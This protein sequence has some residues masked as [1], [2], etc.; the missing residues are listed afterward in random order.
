MTDKKA[1]KRTLAVVLVGLTLG[2]TALAAPPRQE[3]VRREPSFLERLLSLFRL[4][5][6]EDG[7]RPQQGKAQSTSLVTGSGIRPQHSSL[8]FV[9]GSELE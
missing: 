2:A 5:E 4:D 3:T 9:E 8:R 1:V 7:R 6:H